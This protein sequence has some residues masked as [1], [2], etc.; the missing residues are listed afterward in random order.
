MAKIG[1][2]ATGFYTLV[3]SHDPKT[4]VTHGIIL[5]QTNFGWNAKVIQM[6]K[7]TPNAGLQP[8]LPVLIT[9][10]LIVRI[11]ARKISTTDYRLLGV[12]N[13][14]GQH[15]WLSRPMGDPLKQD[16]G[17]KT[18]SLNSS[19]TSMGISTMRLEALLL[20]LRGVEFHIQM[21]TKNNRAE[22]QIN[23][24]EEAKEDLISNAAHL[25]NLCQN[26][27][28][29]ANYQQQRAKTLITVVFN[30]LHQKDA[31]V[32]IGIAADSK[33]LAAAST[34]DSAAMRVIAQATREDSETMKIIA[35]ET[36]K[37]SSAMKT[38]AVLTMFFLPGTFIAAFFAMPLFNWDAP[39]GTSVLK[40]RFN[41]Y[42]AATLP[43]TF[44]VLLIWALCLFLP[45]HRWLAR[46]K[47]S[48]NV[49]DT[50]DVEKDKRDAPK[51]ELEKQAGSSLDAVTSTENCC[52]MTGKDSS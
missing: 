46:F 3:L 35:I 31:L 17:E 30:F 49:R 1:M 7:D 13:D 15:T 36:K 12:E 39:S 19:S 26:M 48:A 43:L 2:H 8:L 25:E 21:M 22:Q 4:S 40:S 47:A 5:A 16:F 34:R 9:A 38:I 28:L 18:R 11:Q 32:N 37:D 14:M 45:W 10:E 6:L 41:F 29:E 50:A 42:W 24:F 52:K 20:V 23:Q 33:S 51:S 44:V 27:L